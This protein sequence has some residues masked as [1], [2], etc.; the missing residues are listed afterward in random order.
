MPDS[1]DWP[2][3]D[4]VLT[5]QD[6]YDLYKSYLRGKLLYI[7]SDCCYSGSWVRKCASLLDK[8]NIYCGHD[9]ERRKIYLKI[10]ASC[11]PTQRARD[12]LYSKKGIKLGRLDHHS[13]DAIL[14]PQ[15]VRL[16]ENQTTLGFDFT[17]TTKCTL[18]EGQCMSSNFTWEQ[19]LDD[20]LKSQPNDEYIY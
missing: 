4:G 7:V 3:M 10:F 1:G 19:D 8:E 13:D 16:R 5:F 15:Y 17:R 14:F 9:A 18:D 2:F 20:L 6:I 11:L 12:G